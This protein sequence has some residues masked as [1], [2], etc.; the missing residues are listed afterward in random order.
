M[1]ESGILSKD[2]KKLINGNI[3]ELTSIDGLLTKA[4][5][6]KK[7]KTIY[8]TSCQPDEGKTIAAISMA[9]TLAE[10][11]HSKVLLVDGN[12][13]SPNIHIAFNLNHSS[14]LC[15]IFREPNVSKILLMDTEFN[16]LKVLPNG[17]PLSKL[18]NIFRNKIFIEVFHSWIQTFDYVIFDGISMS[19]LSDISS[20]TRH[21]DGI[22][23]VIECERTRREALQEIKNKI[24]KDN[25]NI[26]GVVLNKRRAYIPKILE[27]I[28][29]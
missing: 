28:T 14:G 10:G 2:I 23:L 29:R 6:N 19:D 7:I 27:R 25:G 13:I 3:N 11:V 20:V 4:A 24:E 9:Y 18:F 16:N 12:F 26:L 17:E 8:V 21:F 22:A 1:S 5:H 15:D